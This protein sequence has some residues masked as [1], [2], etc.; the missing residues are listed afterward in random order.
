[1]RK[2]LK[3]VDDLGHAVTYAKGVKLAILGDA[4]NPAGEFVG[5]GEA[6]WCL[7]DHHIDDLQ[8]LRD[9]AEEVM[10]DSENVQS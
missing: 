5:A 9:L 2:D 8:R 3:L 4:Y 10:R 7:I 1:M 6:L